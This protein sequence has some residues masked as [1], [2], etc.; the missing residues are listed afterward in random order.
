[1]QKNQD[2]KD[3][4]EVQKEQPKGGEE[5]KDP[6][7]RDKTDR[8]PPESEREKPRSPEFEQWWASLPDQAR[9]QYETQD[10]DS[11]PPKW[12]EFLR[13]WMKKMAEDLEKGR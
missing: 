1:M 8:P 7:P 6:P 9:K 12:R 5:K 3:K 2:P 10:W 11:I 4:P 13:E